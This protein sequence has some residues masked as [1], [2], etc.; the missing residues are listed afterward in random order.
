MPRFYMHVCN[1]NGFAEDEEGRELADA[2]TARSEAI[3]AVRD[4]MAN[5]LRGGELD[6]SSFIE[7][8]DEN[9]K[10]LF[11]VQF[12]DAVRITER[13]SPGKTHARPPRD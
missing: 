8:E 3:A 6:I 1:G 13:H 5:D 4:V 10:L 12:T 11:T 9:K 2:E 7:V